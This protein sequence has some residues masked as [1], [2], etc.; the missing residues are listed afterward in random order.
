MNGSAAATAGRRPHLAAARAPRGVL[1]DPARRMRWVVKPVLWIA[2]LTPLTILIGRTV[3][4]QLGANPIEHVTLFTGIWTLNLIVATLAITPIR[5]LTGWNRIIQ[6][7]RPLGLF[8]FFYATIHFLIYIVLDQFF[9]FGYIV[10]DIMERPYITVGFTAFLLLIPLALT[11]RKSAIRKLG[12]AWQRLHRLVYVAAG[13]GVIHFLWKVKADSREPLIYA[14]ILA[15]LLLV[16]LPVFRR[17]AG[18]TAG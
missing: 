6:L 18:P 7:R 16:R 12:R 4:D 11:S 8:A 3:R 9:A 14:S 5:R 10:E 15:I 2:C 13:L 17:R 1:L